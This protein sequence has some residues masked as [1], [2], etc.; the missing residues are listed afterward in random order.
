VEDRDRLSDGLATALEA[1]LRGVGGRARGRSDAPVV[2]VGSSATGLDG[3]GVA[4]ADRELPKALKARAPAVLAIGK[5][6]PTLLRALRAHPPALLVLTG[7][8]TD[9]E[10][11]ELRSIERLA[12]LGPDAQLRTGPGSLVVCAASAGEL[13][14]LVRAL[15]GPSSF[16]LAVGPTPP[17]LCA[18]LRDPKL[19]DRP[20]VGYVP[21]EALDVDWAIWAAQRVAP[22]VLVPLGVPTPDLTEPDD[23]AAEAAVA[24]HALELR[25]GPVFP[26]PRVLA[27]V[28]AGTLDPS[29][30]TARPDI[31]AL[32]R[33]MW[34]Q[35]RRA[36]PTLG[37]VVG[38]EQPLLPLQV[39]TA[40]FLAQRALLRGDQAEA[41][42]AAGTVSDPA[43]DEGGR[44]R[45]TEVLASA[46][47]TLTD[48]ESKV[49]LRGFGIEVTRQAVANSASGA[50]GFA[51][52]IGYPVVLKALSPDLRRRADI[53]AIELDLSTAA[54]VR[55]AYA[56][57]V[58]A[59]ERNAPTA[60]VDGIAVAEMVEPG[61]DVRCGAV[62]LRGGQMAL[63]GEVVDS[64]V[65][66]EPVLALSPLSPARARAFAHAILSRVVVPAWRRDSDPDVEDLARLLARLDAVVVCFA[67]RLA[68]I[69]LDPVRL[70]GPSRGA[71]VLDARVVQR[72]HVD[73][74]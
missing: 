2:W 51:E 35:A 71:V 9:A 21:A 61:L 55:R 37:A 57:I 26:S 25:T 16:A 46:S 10:L 4:K 6:S 15:G 60:R 38:M 32:A 24:A 17:W 29:L 68:T 56:T 70:C 72:P 28:L 64:T 49:V 52:R 43:P 74:R 69:R 44:T 31:P 66:L 27:A 19:R 3:L 36:L 22:F 7:E 58:E 33:A 48:Q 45:A 42:A 73:G 67:A 20:V 1:V 5:V 39:P 41:L 14:G 34:A 63:F 47:T 18:W 53:G 11:S 54:A 12:L 23:P 50:V 40:A 59:V 65:P 8:A 62:R 13:D 30:R